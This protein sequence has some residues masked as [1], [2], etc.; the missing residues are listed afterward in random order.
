[1]P[2][3]IIKNSNITAAAEAL[4]IGLCI[5]FYWFTRARGGPL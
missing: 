1:M 5:Y 4:L 2:N 3:T